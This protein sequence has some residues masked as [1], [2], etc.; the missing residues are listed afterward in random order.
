[1]IG[2]MRSQRRS[3]DEQTGVRRVEAEDEEDEDEEDKGG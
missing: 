3:F 2:V 1:M